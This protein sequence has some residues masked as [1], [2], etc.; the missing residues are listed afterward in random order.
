MGAKESALLGGLL[1]IALVGYLRAAPVAPHAR[2]GEKLSLAV[3]AVIHSLRPPG[4][5][6]ASLLTDLLD[7]HLLQ[8]T[9]HARLDLRERIA[10]RT[11]RILLAA[12]LV[13]VRTVHDAKLAID[14]MHH[15]GDGDVA[16]VAAEP[17]AAGGTREGL[18]NSAS[19]EH[20]HDL[21]QKLD[22]NIVVLG[23]L[24]GIDQAAAFLKLLACQVRKGEQGIIRSFGKAKH[25][26]R[27]SPAVD[28]SKS[29]NFRPF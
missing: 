12:E 21:R 13:A 18:D 8:E 16:R 22:R 15:F 7:A 28:L 10:D 9:V 17:V 3:W 19:R 20:L 2:V 1:L 25:R 27:Q 26:Y 11:A 4:L 6:P 23:D 14:H 24:L 5:T 29:L